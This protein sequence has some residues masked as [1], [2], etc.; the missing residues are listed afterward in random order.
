MSEKL[1]ISKAE[2]TAFTIDGIDVA[3]WWEGGTPGAYDKAV[4]TCLSLQKVAEMIEVLKA[5]ISDNHI[6]GYTHQKQ[7]D[8]IESL[9]KEIES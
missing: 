1:T 7:L 4:R 9:L 2:S 5:V 6:L 3:L 8:R